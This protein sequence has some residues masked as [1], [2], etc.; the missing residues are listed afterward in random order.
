M[1]PDLPI[2]YLGPERFAARPQVGLRV[3]QEW[4][5]LLA[6]LTSPT[7]APDKRAAGAWCPAALDGGRVRGGSGPVSLLVAD[8]DECEAGAL[9]RSG[10]ALASYAGAV[11]PTFSATPE[12][13]KH[14]IVLAL[15]RPLD[16]D[17]F[18]V[19]WMHFARALFAAGITLDRGCKNI[20]RLYFACASPSPERWAELGGARRLTGWPVPVDEVLHTARAAGA[21]REAER[22]RARANRPAAPAPANDTRRAC[23]VNAAISREVSNIYAASEGGRHDALVRAAFRLARFS[24]VDESEIVEALLGPFLAVAGEPRRREAERSIRDAINARRTGAA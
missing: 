2:V 3:T 1:N 13:P 14:R 6:W 17:E 22:E 11:I 8:V 16:P 4:S 20:N 10:G 23:Y 15:S 7:F 19:V 24:D 12:K 18:P 21:A 5:S 9:E